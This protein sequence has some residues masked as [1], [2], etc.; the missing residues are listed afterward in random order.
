MIVG[1]LGDDASANVLVLVNQ[2]LFDPLAPELTTLE[3][4][5]RN[6]SW[7]PAFSVIP[8]TTAEE[9]RG[10]LQAIYAEQ[11]FSG[12]FLIGT[13]PFIKSSAYLDDNGADWA[14][15]A[16]LYLMDLDG[17]WIDTDGDG[18]YDRL[19]DGAGDREPEIFVGRLN[20]QH[21]DI[22]G[23]SEVD[24]MKRY[25]ARNHAYRTGG[26]ATQ[27]AAVYATYAHHHY[28]RYDSASASWSQNE[29]D[30]MVGL[31][32]ETEVFIFD[33]E[34]D[35]E[36]LEDV[37]EWPAEFWNVSSSEDRRDVPA[38]QEFLALMGDGY[39]YLSIGIHGWPRGWEYLFMVEDVISVLDSGGQLPVFVHS[40]SCS[41]G[42]I[43]QDNDLGSTL[44]MGGSLVFFGPAA[45]SEMTW[46]EYVL[47]TES[48]VK[49]PVGPAFL[50]VQ[51]FSTA[52]DHGPVPTSVVWILL[53]DPTLR[54][55]TL[56]TE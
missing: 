38:R 20:A 19:E 4:D 46:E 22:F 40:G 52:S 30:A 45:P 18:L 43:S 50:E 12:V 35:G 3:D 21:V 53:G 42:N 51:A 5:M 32:P 39:H 16:D 47:W 7:H 17:S 24:L 13:F 26:L 37:N 15:P 33:D 14:G 41:T 11:P 25:F 27:D 9:L 8:S 49:L 2:E 29:I 6:E 1:Q 48:L 31:L 54:V 55:R 36:R 28:G 34:P 44:T 56:A 23:E 10:F